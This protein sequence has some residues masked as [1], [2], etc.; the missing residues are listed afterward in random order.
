M[1]K[2]IG[3][4]TKR[5][6]AFSLALV[7]CVTMLPTVSLAA[8][9]TEGGTSDPEIT[10][11]TVSESPQPAALSENSDVDDPPENPWS[12]AVGAAALPSSREYT[13]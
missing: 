6:F 2:Q 12:P 4:M 1:K 8:E 9:E 3:T 5:G 13:V 10:L 7:M 11:V